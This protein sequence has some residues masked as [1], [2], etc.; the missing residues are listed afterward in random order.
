M[1]VAGLEGDYANAVDVAA[2]F[3][4]TLI[5]VQNA[6]DKHWSVVGTR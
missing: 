2:K 3:T 6:F 5:A 4:Q 1:E